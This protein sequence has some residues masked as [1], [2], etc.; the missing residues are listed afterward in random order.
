MG[1][2]AATSS[3]GVSRAERTP[4]ARSRLSAWERTRRHVVGPV[5]QTLAHHFDAGG[6]GMYPI[7]V[8]SWIGLAVAL[9]RGAVLFAPRVRAERLI[10][11]LDAVLEQGDVGGAV[12]HSLYTPGA[13][14]RIARAGLI[15]ALQAVPRIEAATATA[16]LIELPKLR[17]GID[18]LW[19][20]TQLATLFGLLGTVMGLSTGFGFANADATSR[21]CMLARGIAAAMNCTAF[22]LLVSTL[23]L[24]AAWVLDGRAKQLRKELELVALATKN[25]LVDRRPRLL[26]HG[27]RPRVDRATYRAAA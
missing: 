17:R 18:T 19:L 15:E 21:A 4:Q 16:L 26:W 13:V 1:V 10:L 7:L 8:C 12:I 5:V 2:P 20:I 9:G 24:A 6:W 3:I 14:G 23:A 27:A 25:R 22:G 11:D